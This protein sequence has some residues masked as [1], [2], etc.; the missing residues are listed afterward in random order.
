[1]KTM[2]YLIKLTI[3]EGITLWGFFLSIILFHYKII[4]NL[5]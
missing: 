3:Y 2:I 5:I 1:M 4:R